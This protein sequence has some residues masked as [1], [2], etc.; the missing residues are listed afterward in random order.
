MSTPAAKPRKPRG[1]L[2]TVLSLAAVIGYVVVGFL[3]GQRALAAKRRELDEKRQFIATS[4]LKSAQVAQLELELKNAKSHVDG[5]RRN[6]GAESSA[7]TM[8][9]ELANL[10]R[11]SG[12]V[13]HRLTPQDPTTM[14]TLRQQTLEIEVEGTFS[15]VVEFLRGVES[16]HEAIWVASLQLESS[17]QNGTNVQ[18]AL[19][20]VVFADNRGKSG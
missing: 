17:K 7:V 18:C 20:L 12:V 10:A 1:L 3:P 8:L 11:Q 5:W 6:S 14:E 15:Q 13:L 19:G 4:E 2:V 16:R 9:G